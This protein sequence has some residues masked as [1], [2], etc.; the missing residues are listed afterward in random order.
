MRDEKGV[1][2]AKGKITAEN[3]LTMTTRFNY[4]I[5]SPSIKQLLRKNENLGFSEVCGAV[6]RKPIGFEPATRFSHGCG[7]RTVVSQEISGTKSPLESLVGTE[8][9]APIFLAIL[10][11]IRKYFIFNMC[12]VASMLRLKSIQGSGI[13]VIKGLIKIKGTES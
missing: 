8:P 5:N 2:P 4:G 1:R 3:L 6:A 12:C 13:W 9:G 7:V 11:I 10:K